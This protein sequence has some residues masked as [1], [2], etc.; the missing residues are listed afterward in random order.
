MTI[1]VATCEFSYFNTVIGITNAV[2]VSAA[3]FSEE[4]AEE[5][6]LNWPERREEA[7]VKIVD[8]WGE[9]SYEGTLEWGG[10]KLCETPLY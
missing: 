9:N 5:W 3:F 8:E 2:Y 4:K 10:S 6:C 7:A 1:F